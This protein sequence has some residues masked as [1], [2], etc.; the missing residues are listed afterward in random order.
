MNNI[1]GF[2]L[3]IQLVASVTFPVGFNI[4][5]F[6]DDA[7][8]FDLP[9]LQV[10]DS[11]MG[12]NGDLITWA[13]ANPIKITIN[14]VPGSDEDLLLG[15]LLEANRAGKGKIVARD[16]ITMTGIYP[17][18]TLITLINGSITDGMPGNSVASEGRMKSKAYVF[19]FENKV[20]V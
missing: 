4:S 6:A 11:A 13:K 1:S 10:A 8:P 17:D 9:S 12:L 2:G 14:V 19:A 16:A 18:G 15:I 5:Q 7:D 20:N 3:Q